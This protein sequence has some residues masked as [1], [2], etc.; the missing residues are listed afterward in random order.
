M[1]LKLLNAIKSS[2]LRQWQVCQ[3]ACI[4]ETR[5]SRIIAEN[6]KIASNEERT[7]LALALNVSVSSIFGELNDSTGGIE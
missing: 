5:L 3:K 1:N 6:S 7:R 4:T 2:G